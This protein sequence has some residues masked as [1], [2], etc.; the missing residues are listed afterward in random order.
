MFA[1]DPKRVVMMLLVGAL[2]LIGATAC[3]P[4]VHRHGLIRGEKLFL[5]WR[6]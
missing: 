1:R 6:D 3:E 4:D 5:A 2:L